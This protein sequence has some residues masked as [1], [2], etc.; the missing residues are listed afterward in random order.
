MRCLIT[1][2]IVLLANPIYAMASWATNQTNGYTASK[3]K[4]PYT[5]LDAR[6]YATTVSQ[7][8]AGIEQLLQA[9][10]PYRQQDANAQIAF[11]AQQLIDIPYLSSGAVGEGDWQAAALHYQPGAVHIRQDPVYR[12]DGFNCQTFVQF[13]MAMLYANNLD[14]FDQTMLA[15]SYG[16]AGNPH[17]EIVH[18]YNRN[19]FIDG[20]WNRVNQRNGWLTDVTARGGLAAYALRNHA[21][22]TRQNWFLL[23]QQDT[24]TSVRVLDKANGPAMAQRSATLYTALP[25]PNF[26]TEN[27]AISYTPK[28]ILG[29]KQANGDYLPNQTILDLIPTPAILEIVRD[30][31][32]WILAGK[33][34]KDVMGS[35]TSI[36]HLGLLYRQTFKRGSLIYHHISCDYNPLNQGVCHV[37]PI[38]CQ[39][40]QCHE[41]MFTHA[42]DAYPR[43]FYWYQQT[44]GN[45][46]CSAT[47]PAT[48]IAYT[49][50]NRVEAIP[51]FEYLTR[52]QYHGYRYITDPSI[53][54]IHIEHLSS[55]SF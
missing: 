9:L 27:V 49:H 17:G 3:L 29:L 23:R 11:I 16:A 43:Q 41:L 39:K 21:T 47:K 25:Y 2:A 30:P 26:M 12:L 37:T 48:G 18:S 46:V 55:P 54:G 6:E 24:A 42:T 10:Q 35:E 45:V 28:E 14:D 44:S 4:Q 34:I 13:V 1:L 20:D 38:T 31:K 52:Y 5:V 50:C 33:N 19:H 22:L 53:V 15:I 32:K 40:T 36:S 51:L 7:T 8:R